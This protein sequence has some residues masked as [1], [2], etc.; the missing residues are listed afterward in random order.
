[1]DDDGPTTVR[2]KKQRLKLRFN[3]I[4]EKREFM[5]E[6]ENDEDDNIDMAEKKNEEIQVSSKTPKKKT[7][8][9]V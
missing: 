1:M 4:T 3:D 2:T 5:L 9:E 8:L 7:F 6:D